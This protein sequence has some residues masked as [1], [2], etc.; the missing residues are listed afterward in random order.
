MPELHA[1]G[2]DYTVLSS[3]WTGLSPFLIAIF[4]PVERVAAPD[5]KSFVWRRVANSTEVRAPITDGTID[6]TVNWNSPFENT[7][8]DQK[9]SSFSALLQ[10]GGFANILQ[11]LVQQKFNRLLEKEAA[12]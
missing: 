1:Q 10:S 3:D 2:S 4:Y 12:A 8:V 6:S 9:F 7:G 5:N 11:A